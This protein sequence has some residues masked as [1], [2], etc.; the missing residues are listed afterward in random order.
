MSTSNY[1]TS[2]KTRNYLFIDEKVLKPGTYYLKNNYVNVKDLLIPVKND[3]GY[4]NRLMSMIQC[5]AYNKKSKFFTLIMTRINIDPITRK[6]TVMDIKEVHNG[7]I[8][9][10]RN[11]QKLKFQVNDVVGF[12]FNNSGKINLE[13][14]PVLI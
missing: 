5:L 13:F 4:T 10:L 12:Y 3:R 1:L 8:I 9:N 11:Y 6:E 7:D 14:K 2:F